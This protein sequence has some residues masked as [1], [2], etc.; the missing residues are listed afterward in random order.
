MH[1]RVAKRLRA[2]SS[3]FLS[4]VWPAIESACGGG[5]IEPVESVTESEFTKTLDILGGI[6]AWQ[7]INDVGVRGIASRVQWGN[8]WRTFTVRKALWSG[9]ETEWHRIQRVQ[10]LL[11]RG[12]IRAH[13]IVQAYLSGP[14]GAGSDLIAAYIIR[15]PDLYRFCDDGYEG[16]VWYPQDVPGGNTMA[17][18]HV[19]RL[20]KN[21][22]DVK[23]IHSPAE[24]AA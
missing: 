4:V 2:S 8:D 16:D 1:A 12:F 18:F 19:D 11:D 20:K 5:F 9:G 6:D 21:G 13:L 22:C 7:V 24:R 15:A 14:P 23:E 3:D 17:V 10:P